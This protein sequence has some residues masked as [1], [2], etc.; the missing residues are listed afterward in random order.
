MFEPVVCSKPSGWAEVLLAE[1]PGERFLLLGG[2]SKKVGVEGSLALVAHSAGGRRSSPSKVSAGSCRLGSGLAAGSTLVLGFGVRSAVELRFAGA[3][4][5]AI[6]QH[7]LASIDSDVFLA[8]VGKERRGAKPSR[9][10]SN[11]GRSSSDEGKNMPGQSI[12]A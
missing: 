6:A 5:S 7:L 3:G 9:L 10:M 12:G 4:V 8:V 11:E 1:A 2:Q